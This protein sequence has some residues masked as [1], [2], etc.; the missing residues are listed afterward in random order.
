ADGDNDIVV[1][2]YWNTVSIRIND[3]HGQ[4]PDE[5]RFAV[6]REPFS[7]IA[8]D[9][10][11]DEAID[12]AVTGSYRNH[13]F[14]YLSQTFASPADTCPYDLNDDG[15]VDGRDLAILVQSDDYDPSDRR[16]LIASFGPCPG[17]ETFDCPCDLNDD[18]V[19]DVQDLLIL[20]HDSR[21]RFKVD[22]L[23]GLLAAWGRCQY[24]SPTPRLIR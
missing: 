16:A 13:V 23:L 1:S 5:K 15:V 6:K 22:D 11:G 21:G 19:V 7:I 12:L 2:T 24:G 8:A 14:L 9:F 18:E 4:F 17:P 3:G 20:L 10:D